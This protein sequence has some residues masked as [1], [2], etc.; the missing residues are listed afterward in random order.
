M[1]EKIYKKNKDLGFQKFKSKYLSQHQIRLIEAALD[2]IGNFG[3][4]RLVVEKG[5]IR[6]IVTQNSIDALN[7]SSDD[8][9]TMGGEK[10]YER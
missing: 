2:S 1:S 6:F 9:M 5:K 10:N 3:E 4:V 7:C 8:F